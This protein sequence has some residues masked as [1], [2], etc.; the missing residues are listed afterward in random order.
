M[1]YDTRT[2]ASS[3][4]S[5]FDKALNKAIGDYEAA[6]LPTEVQFRPVSVSSTSGRSI[7]RY[8]ALV[9]AGKPE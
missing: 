8:V 4:A 1:I 2:I 3:N 7:V 9:I 5:A 6:G